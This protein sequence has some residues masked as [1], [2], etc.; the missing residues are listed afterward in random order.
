[1]EENIIYLLSNN[2]V[3]LNAGDIQYSDPENH[4]HFSLAF[5]NSLMFA[6]NRMN[7]VNMF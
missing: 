5:V 3:T 1:M 2:L 7:S 4:L 6:L